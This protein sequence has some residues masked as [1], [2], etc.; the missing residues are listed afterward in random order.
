MSTKE[1]GE[2]KQ[3]QNSTPVC[4]ERERKG[5]QREVEMESGKGVLEMVRCQTMEQIQA[6]GAKRVVRWAGSGLL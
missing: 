2:G 1:L 6:N 5:P 3:T 4:T